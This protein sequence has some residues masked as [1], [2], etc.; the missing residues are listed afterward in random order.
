MLLE[1]AGVVLHE[2]QL[3]TKIVDWGPVKGHQSG[4]VNF[5]G[6]GELIGKIF[7]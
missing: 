3:A 1:K 6:G 4:T 7:D 5:F 2:I